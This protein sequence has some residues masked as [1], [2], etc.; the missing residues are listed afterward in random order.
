MVGRENRSKL[1]PGM[2]SYAN[3]VIILFRIITKIHLALAL[4]ILY[5]LLRPHTAAGVVAVDIFVVISPYENKCAAPRPVAPAYG[6]NHQSTGIDAFCDP[7]KILRL[8]EPGKMK[9]LRHLFEVAPTGAR[10]VCTAR[11]TW[12]PL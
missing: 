9:V 2:L 5:G 8:Y 12:N 4:E 11:D 1:L 7:F 10:V 6:C 3:I